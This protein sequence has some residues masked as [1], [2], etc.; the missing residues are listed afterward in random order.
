MPVS[1]GRLL[2]G[3]LAPLRSAVEAAPE[4]TLSWTQRQFDAHAE[5]IIGPLRRHYP[6][7]STS[8]FA[9]V[10]RR[11]DVL[12]VLGDGESF[13]T[14]Y[15]ARLL[16]RSILGLEGDRHG[17][18]ASELRAVMPESDLPELERLVADEA[19]VRIRYAR[20][21]GAFDV[22][23]DLVQPVLELVVSRYLGA[24]GP[25]PGIQQQWARDIFQDLFLNKAGLSS[26]RQRARKASTE[27]NA[28]VD[29][30]VAAARQADPGSQQSTT[31]LNRLVARKELGEG[32]PLAYSDIRDFL[33]MLAIGWL[34][35]A[36]KAALLCLDEL[37]NRPA[38]LVEAQK[39]A[40]STDTEALRRVLWETLRFRAVQGGL[41]RECVRPVT[42][43]DG[44]GRS[45]RIRKG[46]TVFVGTHSAMWD[47]DAIPDPAR[48]DPTRAGAQYLIF[49]DGLHRCFGEYIN[50]VQIPALLAPL[51]RRP[52]LQRAPGRA[53]RL[54]WN[55]SIPTRLRVQF[56]S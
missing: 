35:H 11:D 21:T 55:G 27:M 18:D 9:M 45:R 54:V 36:E 32:I 46:A 3:A 2:R 6:I 56:E 8:R 30:L 13:R 51:L 24:P 26:V 42:I 10:T 28:H 19:H 49:G 39:A 25:V 15:A 47:E 22:A 1:V 16:G 48:F 44:T 31:V 5:R 52:G 14:P 40:H 7:I 38:A 12:A 41:M 4:T 29:S 50:S 53:G 33:V 23:V 37:L 34:W 43:A 20:N 17:I